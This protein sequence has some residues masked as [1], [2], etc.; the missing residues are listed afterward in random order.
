[1][2]L[3]HYGF[4]IKPLF[5]TFLWIT[6]LTS[7]L[8]AATVHVINKDPQANIII[9][10][11]A[12][13]TNAVYNID[14]A[15]GQHRIQS[16][17][18]DQMIFDDIVTVTNGKTALIDTSSQVA[19][20]HTPPIVST[21]SAH[22]PTPLEPTPKLVPT[23]SATLTVIS[24]IEDA[25]IVID[26]QPFSTNAIYNLYLE[27]GTHHVKLMEN[28]KE[29]YSKIVTLYKDEP[30]TIDIR[31][32]S[33]FLSPTMRKKKLKLYKKNRGNMAL[34][35]QLQSVS[36]LSFKK[37][38]GP[39]GIQING[40]YSGE[41]K[42]ND[43]R[44]FENN[45]E[46]KDS[47]YA[48]NGR[49]MLNLIER[50]TPNETRAS[51]LYIGVGYGIS[52]YEEYTDVFDSYQHEIEK[53]SLQAFIGLEIDTFLGSFSFGAEYRKRQTSG[54]RFYSEDFFS[55]DYYYESN[56]DEQRNNML[57]NL[58]YSYYF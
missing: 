50:L 3:I 58:G 53:V 25:Y 10:G 14:L 32:E 30:E 20:T 4:M 51:R 40:W 28:D 56:V 9:N 5:L 41:D 39:V 17:K 11:K 13:Y 19:I 1:M 23:A 2:T 47:D 34:G 44:L 38:I 12:Y 15:E 27:P 46:V 21:P 33:A 7:T 35:F 55:D 37:Y 26:D 8:C 48:L 43:Y 54:K 42:T 45:N 31:I 24:D 57:F 22:S 16:K 52:T 18:G 49:I 6:G 29:I 36:G